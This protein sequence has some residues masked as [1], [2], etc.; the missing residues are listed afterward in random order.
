MLDLISRKCYL[1]FFL[2][3]LLGIQNYLVSAL[4]YVFW[5]TLFYLFGSIETS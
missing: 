5:D 1:D 4:V 2:Q 3:S